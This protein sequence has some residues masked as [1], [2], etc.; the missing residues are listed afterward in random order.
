MLCS[1]LLTLSLSA[2]LTGKATAAAVKGRATGSTVS[3]S[4][5]AP[6]SAVTV[7]AGF[8]GFGF[9]L[10]FLTNYANAF[11]NN[12]VES[13]GSR[14]SVP[15]VIR[16]GGTS[17][18]LLSWNPQQTQA[19]T[20]PSGADPTV[21]STHFTL[22]PSFFN[23]FTAFPNPQFTWQATMPAN[24]DYNT[25]IPLCQNALSTLG[26]RLISFALGNEVEVHYSQVSAYVTNAIDLE[27]HLISSLNLA[28]SSTDRFEVVDSLTGSTTTHKP[29]AV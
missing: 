29:Y 4:P 3:A 27:N 9:E 20:W 10:P 17:G 1:S 8:V 15:P 12:L 6:N 21:V 19:K 28:K 22:G 5:T 14:M 13:V 18:D 23:S 24:I 11:S 16:L 2:G 25:T 26:N 7:P